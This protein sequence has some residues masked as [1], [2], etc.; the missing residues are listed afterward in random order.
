MKIFLGGT[1]TSDWRDEF[2]Y[3][4]EQNK[5]DYF[6]PVVEDWTPEC[7]L[8]EEQEKLICDYN[9]FV[10]TPNMKGFYSI[11][12]M[13][14]MIYNNPNEV[15]ICFLSLDKIPCTVTKGVN[16]HP[17]IWTEQQTRSIQEIERRCQE[18]KVPFFWNLKDVATYLTNQRSKHE[19]PKLQSGPT[20][21]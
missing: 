1:C 10:I 2:K 8:K 21:L 19:S 13:A 18:L 15:V 11:W 4:L 7:A 12:E 20:L 6:D 17:I 16:F 14:T 3:F 5:I 9:L